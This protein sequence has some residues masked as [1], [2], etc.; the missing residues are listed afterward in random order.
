VDAAAEEDT[1]PTI[2]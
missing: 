1:E 2:R